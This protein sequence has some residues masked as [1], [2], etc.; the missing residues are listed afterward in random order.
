MSGPAKEGR[1]ASPVRRGGHLGAAVAGADVARSRR[2]KNC[3]VTIAVK[4]M[5]SIVVATTLAF[6]VSPNRSSENTRSGR[7]VEPGAETNVE[8][9]TSSNENVNAS[10][11]PATIAGRSCGNV[12]PQKVLHRVAPR[13]ADASSSDRSIPASRAL[14]TSATTEVLNTAWVMMIAIGPSG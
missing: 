1:A 7:V 5:A 10:R 8:R 4:V 2:T 6:G 9:T 13:S 12:T 3:A 11:A 14:H